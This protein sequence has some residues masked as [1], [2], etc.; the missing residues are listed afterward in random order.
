MYHS[1][2]ISRGFLMFFSRGIYIVWACLLE[3]ITK[4]NSGNNI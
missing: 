4:K 3:T 2:I 1:I